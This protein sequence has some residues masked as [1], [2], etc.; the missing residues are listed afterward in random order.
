M[1]GEEIQISIG[2]NF[3]ENMNV[4]S[5]SPKRSKSLDLTQIVVGKSVSPWGPQVSKVGSS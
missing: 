5:S 2:G 4:S 1:V 3:I